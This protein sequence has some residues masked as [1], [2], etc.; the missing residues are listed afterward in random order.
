LPNNNQ[1]HRFALTT[2]AASPVQNI[3][4]NGLLRSVP[5]AEL[6]G[7]VVGGVEPTVEEGAEGRAAPAAPP[8]AA[9]ASL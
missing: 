8:A 2:A 5:D 9:A 6:G 7:D 3:T 4:V 1:G